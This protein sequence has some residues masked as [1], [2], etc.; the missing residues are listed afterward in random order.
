[1]MLHGHGKRTGGSG[2]SGA[3]GSLTSAGAG[4][5]SGGDAA[6]GSGS[7]TGGRADSNASSG[8]S[9][10]AIDSGA[11]EVSSAARGASGAGSGPFLNFNRSQISATQ[12]LFQASISSWVPPSGRIISGA[13][14]CKPFGWLAIVQ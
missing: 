3:F 1:M 13:L 5:S 4:T 11:V 2:D 8:S 10:V 6:L 12:R 14:Q 7:L 9:K